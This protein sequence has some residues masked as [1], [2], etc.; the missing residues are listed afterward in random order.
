MRRP[1]AIGADRFIM[2]DDDACKTALLIS[3]SQFEKFI[4]PSFAETVPEAKKDHSSCI[5]DTD[6]N[7]GLVLERIA[8]C[9]Y[10]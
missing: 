1:A 4:S 6:G 8:D 10:I 9:G 3:L 2:E 5:K 7:I